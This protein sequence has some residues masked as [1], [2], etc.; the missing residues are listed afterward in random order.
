MAILTLD[1]EMMTKAKNTMKIK[2]VDVLVQ[3]AL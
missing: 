2:S 1:S 3:S